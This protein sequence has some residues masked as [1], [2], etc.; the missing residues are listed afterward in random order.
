LE[1]HVITYA[2]SL[3]GITPEHL[4]GFF[5]GWPNPPSRETFLRLLRNSDEVILALDERSEQ[6][7]GFVTAITD[8]VLAAYIP[9]LEVIGTYRGQGIGKQL[10]AQMVD[11]LGDLYMI[12]LLCDEALQDF[13]ERLGM[14][15]SQGMMIRNYEHQSGEPRT[16]AD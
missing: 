16:V 1:V 9:F 5:E 14:Q 6:V 15:R 2:H 10:V 7:V 3:E 12:D 8:H 11:R 13:Y 4:H